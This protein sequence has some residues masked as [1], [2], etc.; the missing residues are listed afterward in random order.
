MESFTYGT[1]LVDRDNEVRRLKDTV[2][3]VVQGRGAAVWIDGEAGIGKSAVLAAGLASAEELGC[4]VFRATADEFAHRCELRVLLDCLGITPNSPDPDQRA[5]S[6]MLSGA[7]ADPPAA[8][9][10]RLLA[11]IEGMCTNAPVILVIDDMQWADPASLHAWHRLGR[12]IGHLPLLLIAACGPVPHRPDLALLRRHQT[13]MRNSV[14]TLGPLDVAAVAELAG[15]LLDADA[16]GSTLRQ[17]LQGAAGNPCHVHAIVNSLQRDGHLT[18]SADNVVEL[19][20]ELARMPKSLATVIS[21]QLRHVSGS[22]W[23]VLRMAALLGPAF[24]VTELCALSG[25]SVTDLVGVVEEAIV[26]GVLVEFGAQLGFRHPV[27]Q[28][29]LYE[30]IPTPLRLALHN[31]AARALLPTGA[32]IEN[33]AEHLRAALPGEAAV[34]ID[35]WGVDWLLHNAHKLTHRAPELAVDLLTSASDALDPDD[36]RREPLRIRLAEALLLLGRAEEAEKLAEGILAGS[37]DAEITAE[38][39]W[40]LAWSL[41]VGGKTDKARIVVEN[42]IGAGK[43]GKTSNL[44][45][46]WT[47]RLHGLRARTTLSLGQVETA[48]TAA[49][50]ALDIG[51]EA[52]DPFAIGLALHVTGLISLQQRDLAAAAADFD[53]A[54]SELG[55]DPEFTDQLLLILVDLRGVLFELGKVDKAEETL[56]EIQ[57]IA[58]QYGTSPKRGVARLCAAEHL[59]A[60][61]RWDEAVAEL[62]AAVECCDGMPAPQQSRLRCL[63]AVIASHRDE[64]DTVEEHLAA[65]PE[66]PDRCTE[67]ALL[68]Q[69]TLYERDGRQDDAAAALGA[70]LARDEHAGTRHTWLPLLVRLALALDDRDTALRATEACE[71]DAA[72]GSAPTIATAARHCRGMLEGDPALIDAVVEAYRRMDQPPKR[73]QALEDSAVLHARNGDLGAARAAYVEATRI[74]TDLGADWDL[75]RAETRLRPHGMRRLRARR[76]N[77]TTG[78]EALTP[79]ETRVARLVAAGHANAEIA[80]I[81]FASKRTIEVHV[82]R[83]LA[84]LGVRSRVE[85]AIEATRQP[86]TAQHS[87]LPQLDRLCG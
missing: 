52:G 21:A 18:R 80:A 16:V 72:H 1:V 31:H 25:R 3:Q 87:P 37:R 15:Q 28:Q 36:P 47:A 11:L 57:A 71:A 14:I 2:R 23:E 69:A 84:K 7:G 6:D 50:R 38:T 8:A 48:E 65:V 78:W 35:E 20:S 9:T 55:N 13:D 29:A 56:R 70:A 17:V 49:R 77:A 34:G 82:S 43:S 76:R 5:I 53:R 44:A 61:G 12:M 75:L 58:Q 83:I 62:K 45:S 32:R 27:V 39:S 86:G 63:A 59:H 40:F 79:T 10:E 85:I 51:R 30:D 19:T 26:S 24:S 54:L 68:A 4:Q 66:S 81:L 33:V 60:T 46:R 41:T 74:Y 22:T 64:R 73:A 42:A 67:F